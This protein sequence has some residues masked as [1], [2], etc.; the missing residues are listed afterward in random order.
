M[1]DGVEELGHVQIDDPVLLLA[2][3]AAFHDRHD[4]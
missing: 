2:P 1:V 4:L 3:F